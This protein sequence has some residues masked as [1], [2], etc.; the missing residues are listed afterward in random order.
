MRSLAAGGRLTVRPAWLA[1]SPLRP[2]AANR[3]AAAAA[4]ATAPAAIAPR[5][6]V[7]LIASQVIEPKSLYQAKSGNAKLLYDAPARSMPTGA[8][9]GSAA[10]CGAVS[11]VLTALVIFGSRRR[12]CRGQC[13]GPRLHEVDAQMTPQNAHRPL[14]REAAGAFSAKVRGM[15]HR[16]EALS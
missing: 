5:F 1:A 13:D 7:S 12:N 11:R 14:P 10:G 16:A 9:N 3:T 8:R 2:P 6:T 15:A 4:I